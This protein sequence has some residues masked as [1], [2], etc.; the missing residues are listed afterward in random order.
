MN[1]LGYQYLTEFLFCSYQTTLLIRLETHLPT[2][3]Q[4]KDNLPIINNKNNVFQYFFR[5]LKS[6]ILYTYPIY[7]LA[8]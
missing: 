6:S 2:P 4:L 7:T 3:S 1:I 5:T 8:Y